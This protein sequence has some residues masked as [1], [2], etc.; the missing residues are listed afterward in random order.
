MHH[1]VVSTTQIWE[2][3]VQ[4]IMHEGGEVPS[5]NG[6]TKELQGL[7][8]PEL[9]PTAPFIY[10]RGMSFKYACGETLWYLMGSDRLHWIEKF[11]PS[12]GRFSD[13]GKTLNGAYGPK[14][15]KG[16]PIVI[17]MLK[18]DPATRR[19][20]IPLY[21]MT[22]LGQDSKDIPCTL[23]LQFLIRGSKLFMMVH[24]RSNDLFLGFPYDVFAFS[25]IQCL[26]AKYLHIE[27]GT[28]AHFVASGH[29]YVS[30]FKK[31]A[32][33]PLQTPPPDM[34]YHFVEDGVLHDIS[35]QYNDFEAD[36]TKLECG[37]TTIM[38]PIW[39][40]LMEGAEL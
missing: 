23:H 8:F 9:D 31:L 18:Q 33:T 5:R 7:L 27:V 11:A 37:D 15:R 29:L 30:D 6:P 1:Q 40:W 39:R 36:A 26:I 28:Y 38:P 10:T 16:I 20:V 34:P 19:A 3:A 12:Y 17:A 4:A 25:V 21:D 13:N 22:N 35:S 32:N 24:M 2:E 14:I